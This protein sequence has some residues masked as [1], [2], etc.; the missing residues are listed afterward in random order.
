MTNNEYKLKIKDLPLEERP[1]ERLIKHGS[2]A[3]S[4]T[5]LLAIIL[6]SGSKKE[7]VLELSKKLL[8][9]NSIKSLSRKRIN[10]LKNNLGI[11]EAKACQIIAC[12]ELGRR[13]AA[14]KDQS[15]PVIDNAQDIVK[16]FMP[17]L[18]SLKKEHFKGVFLD[19]RKR[20][21]KEETVF[22]GSLN[23]SVIHPREIFQAALEE[24]AAAVILLHNHPSGNPKPSD[25]DIEITRQLIK[26]GEV[27]G[28]E[29][30]DHIII[31]S[32]RY[33]SFR[34]RGYF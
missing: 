9:E 19:S 11:G 4:N 5:E 18:S 30:L 26:A 31:G 33:F 32:K 6:R 34:E 27:L 10:Y 20:I 29:V 8:S 3:L 25:D 12:F 15:N 22:I 28:I 14:F 13:L 17:D 16:L 23:A 7:D 1:R 21:I 2:K 24:G